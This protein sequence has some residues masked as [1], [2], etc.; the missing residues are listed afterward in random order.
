[1]SFRD[2]YNNIKRL[3]EFEITELSDK[4]SEV[5]AGENSIYAEINN[6][7]K[8]PSKHIRS[9][10]TFLYIKALG[11]SVTEKQIDTQLVIELIHNASLIH[12]DIIDGAE[13]RR[14]NK[15]L[16]NIIGNKISVIS[17]D[18]LLSEA[19]K[20]IVNLRSI[21]ILNLFS[22]TL[23]KMCKGEISQQASLFRVPTLEEYLEKTYGKTGALFESALI[24]ALSVEGEV[25][26]S[27][28]ENFAKC[29]GIAFQIRDD[30][31]NVQQAGDDVKNGIYTAPVI[32][33]DDFNYP[34]RG[35]EKA[36]GLLDNYINNAKTCIANLEDNEYKLALIELLELINNE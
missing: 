3:V 16:N 30:I 10:L 27:Q 31:I 34:Q 7:L 25:V 2:K 20:I 32:F 36:K 35:V 9:V 15:T 13:V 5:C 14:A 28:A 17:G 18:Y 26:D 6:Y 8:A 33:S 29:F 1:M 4:L 12:D 11:Q 22:E 23:S 24:S 21:E 19:M